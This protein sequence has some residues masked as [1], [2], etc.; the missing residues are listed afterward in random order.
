MNAKG[1]DHEQAR[2]DPEDLDLDIRLE[3]RPD[4]DGSLAT[5]AINLSNEEK[6]ELYDF[7]LRC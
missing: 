1:K 2:A 7:L 5:S 3:L 6:K 4:G